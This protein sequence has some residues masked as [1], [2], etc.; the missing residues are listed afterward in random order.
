[1][2]LA[3]PPWYD[4]MAGSRTL[5]WHKNLTSTPGKHPN[6]ACRAP[7]GMAPWLALAHWH[8]T[9]AG[10]PS[11]GSVSMLLAEPPWY[12]TMADSRTLAPV[13]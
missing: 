5:A 1:M 10:L 12:D 9:G 6:V 3:E 11:L 4:T 13:Q 8:G 7:L 2:L